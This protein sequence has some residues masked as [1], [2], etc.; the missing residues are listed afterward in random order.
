MAN[1]QR[2]TKFWKLNFLIVFLFSIFYFLFSIST[3]FAAGLVPCGEEGNPCTLCHLFK[4]GNRI[5]RYLMEISIPLG[6]GFMVF[7]G[8]MMMLAGGSPQKLQKSKD[9]IFSAVIGIIIVL[10]SW[11]I[12]ST[13]FHLMTGKLDWPWQEIKCSV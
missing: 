13:F 11:I 12:L 8:V 3:A 6:V 4:M 10:V 2:L 9:I 7:G 1:I 5:I